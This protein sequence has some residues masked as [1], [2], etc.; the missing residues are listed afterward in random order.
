MKLPKI[1]Y[2]LILSLVASFSMRF[3]GTFF[4]A[5]FH[6]SHV[7]RIT[8]FIHAFF[9]L[10]QLLFFIFFLF[11]FAKNRVWPLKI[12]SFLAILGSFAALLI[13]IKNFGIV[14]DLEILQLIIIDKYLHA[15]I[16]V[17]NSIFQLLFFIVFKRILT[18][19]E[20]ISLTRPIIAAIIG[21]GTFLFLHLTF[22]LNLFQLPMLTW[23]QQLSRLVAVFTFP[24]MGLA[25]VLMLYFYIRFYQYIS[26]L[27]IKKQD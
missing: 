3:M 22:L 26:S 10:S 16:P 27:S 12:I 15:S 23:L 5:I 24:F 20:Q 18:D 14:F 13:Y 6:D 21:A 9:M 8:I 25:A 4:P 19:D 2:L 11:S 17:V 1:T 7:V